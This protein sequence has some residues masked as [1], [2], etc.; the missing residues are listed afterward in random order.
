VRSDA[1]R[2]RARLVE[3]AAEVFAERDVESA[4]LEDIARRAGV[5]VGTLYRHF[6][7]RG[8]LVEAVYRAEVETLCA[9]IDGLLAANPPD[10]ALSLWMQR[11]V[12]YAAIKRGLVD[13]LRN[14]MAAGSETFAYTRAL[15]NE[16]M[17]KLVTAAVEA[18]AIRAD[19]DPEDLLRGLHGFCMG[20]AGW[21]ERAT[22]LIQ[23][24]IDGLR[25]GAQNP[26]APA[27]ARAPDHALQASK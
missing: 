13:M 25:Y 12:R 5:G 20:G 15:I 9:D 21:Q 24:L 23:M 8:D 11:F 4:S 27:A 7:T 14:T 18:G 22:R 3:V 26:G 2:N 17:T 6:P 16:T 1:Q 10:V 19:T